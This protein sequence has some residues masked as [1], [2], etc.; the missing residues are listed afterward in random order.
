M[1]YAICLWIK[2][3]RNLFIVLPALRI[4]FYVFATFLPRFRLR[5]IQFFTNL[6]ENVN[7]KFPFLFFINFL[8]LLI[9]I[10]IIYEAFLGFIITM[11]IF[12]FT[13]CMTSA[14]LDALIKSS[15]LL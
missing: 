6:D 12:Y 4:S 9:I 3:F 8:F 13:I 1:I 15:H 7:F 10:C 5:K 11:T 14:Y 2:H